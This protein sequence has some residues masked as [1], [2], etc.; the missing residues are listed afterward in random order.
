METTIDAAGRVVIPK[1]L[2]D[3]VGL[4]PGRVELVVDGAGIRIEPIAA[5]GVEQV[6]R[7]T[8]I[9]ASGETIGDDDVRALRHADQR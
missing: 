4:R 3:E 9:P 2:R 8:V 1:R 5:S 7:R 6:G